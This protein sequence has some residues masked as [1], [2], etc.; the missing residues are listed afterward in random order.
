MFGAITGHLIWGGLFYYSPVSFKHTRWSTAD[1]PLIRSGE[2]CWN[3]SSMKNLLYL[4]KSRNWCLLFIVFH[5]VFI[6]A[7]TVVQFLACFRL[8]SDWGLLSKLSAHNFKL[9]NGTVVSWTLHQFGLFVALRFPG[10]VREVGSLFWANR[11]VNR[12]LISAGPRLER[13]VSTRAV[14]ASSPNSKPSDFI[15][16]FSLF[17]SDG[18]YVQGLKKRTERGPLLGNRLSWHSVK[19]KCARFPANGLGGM[20]N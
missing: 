8:D 10:A 5:G 13:L 20:L 18:H 2:W 15:S 1:V 14:L 11:T 12:W 6:F 19:M 9:A 3:W 4:L 17:T 7:Q 16:I